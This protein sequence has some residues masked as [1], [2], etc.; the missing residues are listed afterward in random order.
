MWHGPA[1]PGLLQAWVSWAVLQEL[2]PDTRRRPR[3]A[4]STYGIGPRNRQIKETVI[5]GG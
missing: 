3:N 1:D 4:A 2:V 5:V